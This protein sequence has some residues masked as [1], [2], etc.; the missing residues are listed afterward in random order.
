MLH[1]GHWTSMVDTI[2]HTSFLTP[3][4]EFHSDNA[5][6]LG[7]VLSIHS[8]NSETGTSR[9]DAMESAAVGR[10]ARRG[11]VEYVNNDKEK[12]HLTCLSEPRAN[13]YTGV[14]HQGDL[15]S[16]H[17]RKCNHRQGSLRLKL[18]HVPIPVPGCPA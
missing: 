16:R 10:S 4:R 18:V 9:T 14:H 17:E 6:R 15:D 7:A 1:V 5:A 3:T 2:A 11:T 8:S 12:R 13:S